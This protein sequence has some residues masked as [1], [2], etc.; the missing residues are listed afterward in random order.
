MDPF[1]R[2]P[3]LLMV[4][5]HKIGNVH[6]SCYGVCTFR[7]SLNNFT[8]LARISCKTTPFTTHY[9]VAIWSFTLLPICPLP[10]FLTSI[11]YIPPLLIFILSIDWILLC[12][13][14]GSRPV[15]THLV[16]ITRKPHDTAIYH[17]SPECHSYLLCCGD[18]L[19]KC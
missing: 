11:S 1:S 9:R 16:E 13:R 4:T 17:S 7:M 6:S 3:T 2:S 19:I 10:P 8:W 5:M 12:K 14:Y 18:F 15:S